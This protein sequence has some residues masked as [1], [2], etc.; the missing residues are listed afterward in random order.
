VFASGAGR[1]DEPAR[2]LVSEDREEVMQEAEVVPGSE[3]LQTCIC[4]SVVPVPTPQRPSVCERCG[5]VWVAEA[6]PQPLA[7]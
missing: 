3:P 6:E 1:A 2:L 4:G 7:N 5:G